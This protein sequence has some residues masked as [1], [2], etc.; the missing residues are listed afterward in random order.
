MSTLLSDSIR[1]FTPQS[2]W[3]AW[4]EERFV[5]TLAPSLRHEELLQNLQTL[6]AR[7]PEGIQLEEIGQSF[8]RRSIQMLTLG[9]GDNRIMLWSQMHG[10]EPSAT[11]A[12]LDIADF[13][14]ANSDQAAI[15]SILE[16]YTLLII[17]MLNPDGA[18]AWERRNAQGID[19][20]RDALQLVTPEGR[21]L[22]RIRDEYEPMLGLNL[23]DQNRMTTVGDTGRLAT[24]SVLAVSG[25]AQSTL[26]RGR[27][28]AKRACAA[29]IEALSPF[30]PGGIARYDGE[31]SP[32]AFGDNITAWGTPV[33]LIETGGF[34]EGFEV[35]DLTRLNFVAI[36]TVLLGLADDDLSAYDPQVYEDIPENQTDSW[37][38]IV[39][40]GGFV[41]QP[42]T[43]ETFRSD[44][45][46]NILR[47]GR[48]AVEESGQT[49]IPS[50]IFLLGDASCHGA[51]TSVDAYGNVL[52]AA[53]DV[54][55]K[56][57]SEKHW[58]DQ[59]NLSRMAQMGVGTIYWVV[60]ETDYV[61]ACSH[62][63]THAIR[64]LPR[65]EVL[66]DTSRFP[67]L[68]FS[69]APPRAGS[70]S[71]AATLEALCVGDV[72]DSRALDSLWIEPADG[73][74]GPARLCKDQ[75]ASFLMV[76]SIADGQI[77]FAN[78]RLISVWLDGHQVA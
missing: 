26:T 68:T 1:V 72:P 32:R 60:S 51:G 77:D 19:I 78:G 15:R 9:V 27:L 35:T 30:I 3:H 24:C 67:V 48:Q 22:K 44:L 34:P 56:G 10:D 40:R 55:V 43:T 23:H 49:R 16:N 70:T 65:I 76:S 61:A 62:A 53:F 71:I 8:L 57:L 74:S 13:L 20:N 58:M 73:I 4:T 31:W 37:S 18:E 25:D 33:V 36:L 28:R 17:P 50:Q 41:L 29:I 11:P 14:L 59:G 64:G 52:L 75:P 69:G 45:A 47:S 5:T 42:G 63:G 2:L 7:Y 39:V 54:G 46:F 66:T 21:L 38:D 12:L 6:V